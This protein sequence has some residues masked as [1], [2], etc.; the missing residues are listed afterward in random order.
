M[1]QERNYNLSGEAM[2]ALADGNVRLAGKLLGYVYSITG[3]V[4]HGNH[5]GRTLGFPT[6]NLKLKDGIPFLPAYGVYAVKIVVGLYVFKGIANA[7]TRPTVDGTTMTVEVNIFDFSGDLYGKTLDVQFI[8]R[9]RAEIK[10]RNL[11]ELVSQIREDKQQAL[12]LLA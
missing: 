11:D 3:V 6:A 4:V 5:L 12:L 1:E 9:I 7:G 10:F 8:D 2:A